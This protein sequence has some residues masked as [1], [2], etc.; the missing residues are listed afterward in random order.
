MMGRPVLVMLFSR[1]IKENGFEIN[2]EKVRLAGTT[3]RMAVTGVTVNKFPNV[4][5]RYVRQISSILN[6][7]REYG[8]EATEKEF[9]EKY[10]KRHRASDKQKSLKYVIKGKL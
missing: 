6:S 8:Y 10:S 3:Q 4:P 5:R 1:I 7:W 9:N 2:Y